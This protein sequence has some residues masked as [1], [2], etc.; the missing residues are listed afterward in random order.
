MGVQPIR[1]V[2]LGSLAGTALRRISLVAGVLGV[3]V[4][5]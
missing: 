2:K 5:G 1:N 4:I 3:W